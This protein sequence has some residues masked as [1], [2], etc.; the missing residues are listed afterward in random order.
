MRGTLRPGPV[1]ACSVL[2]L[3]LWSAPL[4][5]EEAAQQKQQQ[6]TLVLFDTI[7]KDFNVRPHMKKEIQ[8]HVL[9]WIQ[10]AGGFRIMDRGERERIIMEKRIFVMRT[11]DLKKAEEIATQAG[12]RYFLHS[13][14]Q[15]IPRKGIKITYVLRDLSLGKEGVIVK[16]RRVANHLKP[17]RNTARKLAYEA[18]KAGLEAAASKP[19]AAPGK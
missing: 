18:V 13:T 8:K 16:E 19:E 11:P 10:K 3:L 4:R 14:F 17:L 2:G 15:G 5:A 12:W 9:Q 6:P 1:L 7:W